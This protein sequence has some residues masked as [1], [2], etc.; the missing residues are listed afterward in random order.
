MAS[1]P[2]KEPS[3][4]IVPVDIVTEVKD[5]YLDYAMSVI[6][7]RALPDVRD[8]LKPVHR[9]I[10]Y[11]M[12]QLGLNPTSRFRKSALVVGEVLGKYHPHG[13]AACY[14]A[15]ARMAQ[16][17]SLR[18]PL[19]AGQGNFGSVDGDPPAAMRYTEVK[20]APIASELLHDIDKKTVT[21]VPN[22]DDSRV[23]PTVL[24]SAIPNL[25][26]NGTLGIA[27][28]MAT[29]MP[30]H[31]LGEI[32]D[33]LNHLIDNEG[34][35]G[36]DLMRFIKGPDFPTAGVVYNTEDIKHAYASGR[37]GVVV[38]GEAEIVEG[39]T[40]QSEIIITS[41]PY[42]V[43]KANLI[44]QIADL[45]R[46]K[47][48]EGIRDVRDESTTLGD[49]RV[50]I[51]LKTGAYPQKILNALYKHT[52][53]ETS[54]HYNML[55]LVDG[56][57]KLLSLKS[58]LEEFISFRQEIVTKRTRFD[59]DEALAR[60]HILEGLK[61]ALD[62]IDAVIKTIKRS[63]DAGAAETNLM[64]EFTFTE[65]Q[66]KAILEMK[67]QRLAGL[68]RQKV[69]DELKEKQKLIAALRTLLGDRRKIL[70][71]VKRE[72]ADLKDRF[73]DK[74][75]TKVVSQAVADVS[76]EDLVP[77]K[78]NVLVI[79]K[80]GYVKR[81]DPGEYRAQRR[82][83]VG[84]V[85]VDIKEEDFVNIFFTASTHSDLLF[86]TDRGKV[87]QVKMYELPE[88]KRA[89]RGKSL[90]NFL[91]LSS[92]ERVTSVLPVPKGK[93]GTPLSI[94]MVTK[95]GV[96]K[97]LALG[98]L[99]DVRRSGIVAI[100][101]GAGDELYAALLVGRGDQ[102]ILATRQG[103]AIRFKESDIREMGRTARGV[104]GIK[105]K[106]KGDEVVGVGVA[107]GADQTG[108]YLVVSE[109]G[110]GKRTLLKEY[111]IQHRGGSG[112]KTTAV[113][114]K[115]GALIG[116]TVVLAEATE[117]IAISKQGQVIRT[118]LASIPI[119]GRVT[120][121]VRVMRLRVGDSLASFTSL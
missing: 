120:Q 16:N 4:R 85:D 2:P 9:R 72:F 118:S 104:R 8:G 76:P 31:N 111:K 68:E 63:K 74:R 105:L 47:K 121:G 97:K 96:A 98:E 86:F 92:E 46:E 119:L 94:M 13:D 115:T 22:Y 10:L 26:L 14:D 109:K 70:G 110:F 24:P 113:T 43:N 33:A 67:L 103:Q 99:S 11:A 73:G 29:K 106:K 54:F 53:L 5:S 83:G 3:A 20:M 88:G 7:A 77:E 12:H 102:V 65:R 52:E 59:L 25:L 62:H 57:P 49:T 80:G 56:V 82:G 6:V 27:V 89:T 101:L 55:A 78:E 117:L 64:K 42:Q 108:A 69:E 93:K 48:I 100:S 51:E 116:A 87:Y 75:R 23:E 21:F 114:G 45:V 32:V 19:I 60:A 30:P 36:D 34:A 39:K 112:I 28:G 41:I 1:E 66:A 84:V 61:K 107:L 17:F 37:G 50:L 58:I 95:R 79:T 91:P 90:M 81:T 18:Y 15:L 38:R 35:T 44:I 71:V 40:G